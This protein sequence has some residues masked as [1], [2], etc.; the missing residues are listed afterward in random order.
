M[1]QVH[2]R[3]EKE[4]SNN[5]SA[6]ESANEELV[7]CPK[8]HIISEKTAGN[9]E[10]EICGICNENVKLVN[11]ATYHQCQKCDFICCSDKCYEKGN[12]AT[13]KTILRR[14]IIAINSSVNPILLI[15]TEK[16]YEGINENSEGERAK[17]ASLE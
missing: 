2:E 3:N 12:V 17:R 6:N 1:T 15:L 13:D 8:K 7:L 9:D 4:I 5:E 16:Y 10:W 14:I 11:T